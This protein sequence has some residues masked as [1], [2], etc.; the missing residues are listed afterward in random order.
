MGTVDM[1]LSFEYMSEG[2]LKTKKHVFTRNMFESPHPVL[3]SFNKDQQIR[4]V[5]IFPLA[6][7]WVSHGT[8]LPTEHLKFNAEWTDRQ[9]IRKN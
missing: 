5:S 9:S 3:K 4:I 2:V 8:R 1:Q 6:R 7:A